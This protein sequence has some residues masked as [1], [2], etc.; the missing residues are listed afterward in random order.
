MIINIIQFT[1]E[2][3][4]LLEE[5]H[6]LR[7][8]VFVSEMGWGKNIVD[9][10]GLLKDQYAYCSAYFSAINKT[11]IGGLRI[12][13]YDCGS[14]YKSMISHHFTD[15]KS[16]WSAARVATLT[17]MA[18]LKEYRGKPKILEAS[19][20]YITVAS[21][22]INKMKEFSKREGYQVINA[23]ISLTRA[24]YFFYKAG[25]RV[26]DPVFTHIDHPYPILNMAMCVRSSD[27]N[28]DIERKQEHYIKSRHHD[29]IGDATFFEYVEAS[30]RQGNQA[31]N[32][33]I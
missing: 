14:P 11:M 3:K 28:N 32:F 18:V 10:N 17:S 30:I 24:V 26:I 21:A 20:N 6:C 1:A 33:K 13:P 22:L 12:I 9:R 31:L 27:F 29:I 25:F 5:F 7:D 23:N 16:F 8:R 19:G 4:E 2:D 15:D